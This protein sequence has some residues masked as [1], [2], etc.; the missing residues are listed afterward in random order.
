MQIRMNSAENAI[1]TTAPG[2][3]LTTDQLMEAWRRCEPIEFGDPVLARVKFSH[4][5]E[6]FPLGFPVSIATNLPEVLS[7]AEQSWGRFTQQFDTETIRIQV[8]ITPTKSRQCPPTPTCR[9]RDHL[10]TSIADGENFTLSDLSERSSVIWAT[11]AALRDSEY[12]RYFFLECAAMANI[13]ASCAT[14]I[15]AACVAMAGEGVLLCGDSGA[16]K[17]TLSYACAR[18]GWTYITDDA[19]FLVNE[20]NDDVVAGNCHQVRFRPSA[21]MLFPELRGFTIMNRAGVGKPSIEFP[22][23]RQITLA[24]SARVKHIVFLRRNV[25]VQE[26]VPYPRPVARLF[27]RQRVHCMPYRTSLHLAAID[28]LLTREVYELRY[29]ELDWAVDRLESLIHDDAL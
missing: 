4:R 16:G 2:D 28:R 5:G 11:E 26:L 25:S 20:S 14:A 10:I 9:M 7:A 23:E 19:S 8:G 18:A 1:R 21:E 17:S 29:N 27:M 22:T 24:T 13:S 3:V 6:F 12:F 15:H